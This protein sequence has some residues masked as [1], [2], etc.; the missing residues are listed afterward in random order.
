M[1]EERRIKR[2]KALRKYCR[3]KNLLF[4]KSYGENCEKSDMDSEI[5]EKENET[6]Q[7]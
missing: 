6:L 3:R 1:L 5:F 2:M 7:I 4:C